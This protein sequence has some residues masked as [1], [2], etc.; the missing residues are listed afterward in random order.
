MKLKMNL[1]IIKELDSLNGELLFK[2][3]AEMPLKAA[4]EAQS[5]TQAKIKQKEILAAMGNLLIS[6]SKNI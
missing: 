1:E 5:A 4:G 2:I 6:Y 3:D